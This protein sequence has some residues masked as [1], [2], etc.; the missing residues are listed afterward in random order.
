MVPNGRCLVYDE[1]GRIWMEAVSNFLKLLFYHLPGGREEIM[2]SLSQNTGFCA[3]SPSHYLQN[4]NH[5]TR[6]F[7][8]KSQNFGGK[9]CRRDAIWKTQESIWR[10]RLEYSSEKC[11]R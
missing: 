9:T 10:I 6:V 5:L 8:L 7:C 3:D 11:I 2:K 1:V 4:P